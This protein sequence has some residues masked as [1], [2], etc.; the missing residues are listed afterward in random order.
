MLPVPLTLQFFFSNLAALILGRRRGAFAAAGYVLAG[1]AGLPIF[2]GGSGG[3]AYVLHPTFGYLVGFIAGA[4]TAGFVAERLS[5]GMKTWMIAGGANL[6]MLYFL[7]LLHFYFISNL[8]LGKPIGLSAL[9]Y[10]CC[11]VFLPGD[12]LKCLLGAVLAERLRITLPE[13]LLR[14]AP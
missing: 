13:K 9:I 7:G 8:Y 11:L 10:S 1:L 4:W 3:I 2:A 14:G 6:A 12:L 5:P